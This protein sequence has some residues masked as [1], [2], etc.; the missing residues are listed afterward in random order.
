ME[1][2]LLTLISIEGGGYH[3]G[4]NVYLNGKEAFLLVDTGASKTVLDKNQIEEFV[5]NPSIKL[6]N[7]KSTGLGTN[8]MEIHAT[9][10]LNLEIGSKKIENITL[11]LVDLSHVNETYEKLDLKKI[12]GV[13]GSDLLYMF[14]AKIDYNK[15]ELTL[16]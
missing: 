5:K 12:Q 7:E 10:I 14:K 6:L 1:T 9:E 8:S 4:L 16:I 15:L 2:I 13:L 3:L 11:P